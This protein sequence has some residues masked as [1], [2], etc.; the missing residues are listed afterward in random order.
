[1]DYRRNEKGF[2]F[3][4]LLWMLVVLMICLPIQGVIFKTLRNNSYYDEISIQQVYYFIQ[5][6][7]IKAETYKI[8]KDKILLTLNTSEIVTIEQYKD[9]IRRRVDG[10]G[11]E[12]FIRDIRDFRVESL[13]FGFKI[14]IT[15]SKGDKHEKII[16]FY[17]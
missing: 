12:I 5:E 4:T 16:T 11:H 10:K 2:T 15:S 8:D 14:F 17:K 3:Y 7:V 6:E 1:M 9:L 13:E